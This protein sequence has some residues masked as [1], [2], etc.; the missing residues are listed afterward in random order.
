MEL[1]VILVKLAARVDV[2]DLLHA[3][4]A[5]ISKA[6]GG[7]VLVRAGKYYLDSTLSLGQGDSHVRWAAYR[8]ENT[9]RQIATRTSSTSYVDKVAD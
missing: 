5:A 9:Q 3:A 1:R 4:A 8:G 6:G 7:T 2:D